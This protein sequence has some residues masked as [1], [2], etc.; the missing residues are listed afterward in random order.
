M[1]KGEKEMDEEWQYLKN[2]QERDINPLTP[3]VTRCALISLGPRWRIFVGRPFL[4]DSKDVAASERPR[5]L[6]S[7]I[8]ALE[9]CLTCLRFAVSALLMWRRR[10]HAL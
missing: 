2:Q 4:G 10:T 8:F 7:Q 6:D 9:R 1:I 3:H 5:H